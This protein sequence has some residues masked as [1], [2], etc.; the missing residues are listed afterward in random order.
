MTN[1]AQCN[2]TILNICCDFK[3]AL[4]CVILEFTKSTKQDCWVLFLG[5]SPPGQQANLPQAVNT[6]GLLLKLVDASV[7]EAELGCFP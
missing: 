2:N 6:C 7:A 4:R 5:S 1:T 3:C